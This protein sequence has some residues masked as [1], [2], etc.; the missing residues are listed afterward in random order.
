MNEGMGGNSHVVLGEHSTVKSSG[1]ETPFVLMLTTELI[2]V[3]TDIETML[4]LKIRKYLE[5][6]EKY[7]KNLICYLKYL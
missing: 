5:E 3:K 2:G 1:H 6:T 7:V 4:G